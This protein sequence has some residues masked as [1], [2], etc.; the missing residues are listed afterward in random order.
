MF[1]KVRW[2]ITAVILIVIVAMTVFLGAGLVAGPKAKP[3]LPVW[4]S[5]PKSIHPGAVL[6]EEN[7]YLC[8]ETEL[9]YQGPVPAEMIGRNLLELRKKYMEKDGWT[10]NIK[11]ENTVVLSKSVNDFCGQH[12]LYRH[13]GIYRDSLAVYQGPL[14]FNHKLLRVENKKL[15]TLPLGLRDK[16]QKA[17]EYN[18]LTAEERLALERDLQFVDE[19][20]LNSVLENLDEVIN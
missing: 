6:R 11:N 7:I 15:E 12:S 18:S 8:G 19:T 20:V 13:L 3:I 10:V 2:A 17:L 14:G 9:V 5:D 4:G 1:N 16:L